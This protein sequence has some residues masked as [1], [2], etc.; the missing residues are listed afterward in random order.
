MK[1]LLSLLLAASFIL[2]AVVFPVSAESAEAFT[3][4][5]DTVNA[6]QA[7]SDIVVPVRLSG[8]PGISG[9]SFC[10]EYDTDNLVLVKSEITI[11][12]G[13]KVI[14]ETPG[15]GLNLAWTGTDTYTDNGTVA[16]LYFNI[17]PDATIGKADVRIKYR[18][19]YDS[20]YKTVDGEEQDIAVVS[21]NGG[22]NISN[23]EAVSG[24]KLNVGNASAALNETNIVIPISVENNTGISGFSFCVNYDTTRL[25]LENAD[26]A[27]SDGYKVTSKPDGYEVNIAWTS[28][29]GFAN[30]GII[31]NLHFSVKEN[32]VPGKGYINVLFRDSYDSFYKVVGGQETDV[33]CTVIN[34][35]I[36]VADHSYGDWIIVKEATCKETGLK[37]RICTDP[38]C[39]KTDEVIIPKAPHQYIG[40]VV[41]ATCEEQ[42]F[43]KHT[44]SV[45][46]DVFFDNYTDALPHSL[47]EWE[48]TVAPDCTNSGEEVQKCTVCQAVIN[49]R[50]I[51]ALGHSYGEWTVFKE[52]TFNE[53]G[54]SRKYCSKCDAYK[55]QR[56]PKLSETHTHDYSGTEEIITPA[57][58]TA[59]G[60]K[61]VYCSETECG[62]YIIE[63]IPKLAHEYG[64]WQITTEATFDTDGE[65]TRQ[66]KHCDAIETERIPKL[67]E[68]HIHD[69]TGREEIVKPATCTE[70]GEKKVYCLNA[71]CG[72]YSVVSIDIIDH[73]KGDWEITEQPT[74]NKTGIRVKKCTVCGKVLETESIAMTEHTLIDVVTP[75]TST[76]QG[77][78]THTCTECGYSY[79]DSYTD[80]VEPHVHDFSG[81][82]ELIEA[83]T[84]TKE[85][86]KK[87]YCTGDDCNEYTVVILPKIA[88]ITG[89]WEIIEPATCSKC[90]TKAKKCTACGKILETADVEMIPHS[91][92]DTVIP[93]TPTSQGYTIHRC[94]VCGYQY[95]DSYTDYV[96]ENPAKVV[97]ESKKARAGKT[98]LVNVSLQ[99][100]PGIWGMDLAVNYDKTKLTLIS[101]VNGSVFSDAEWTQG[102]LSGDKY[103]LSYEAGGFENITADGVIAILEFAVNNDAT[104]DEFYD[105]TVSYN[106][107]DI[108]DIDFNEINVAVVSGGVKI[109]EFIYGDLNGDGYINKKDSLLMKMYLADNSTAIDTDAADVFADGVINK[110]DS[111][112]LKQFLA[113]LDVELGA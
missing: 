35:Y 15:D 41:P 50:S 10:V 62:S 19:G 77:Y 36:D 103:I 43:T 90:G 63:T 111:L 4:S 8:N 2:S 31:A 48:Q 106:A 70:K 101:V 16:N 107:G 113:G 27:L 88:H 97:I 58:C 21:S 26:I 57:T 67:S 54:E 95:I 34:G 112:Y 14:R 40:T 20:F 39:G 86:S 109:I 13:Y 80:Y 85:G 60:S 12:S 7:Q 32:A 65:K 1:K 18:D 44:C 46:E 61:K 56:I 94:S 75:P 30:N 55:T 79:M 96:E 82:E 76:S 72:E 9:F 71:S 11:D 51:A 33:V 102:N 23:I 87:V 52:A 5:V 37:R 84:C 6:T 91:Y 105:I 64:E 28:E 108:I 104:V 59:E 49:R 45:C 98:V 100:N 42:G 38:D 110:K 47:G 53:D 69:F 99:N 78:T 83:A 3:V 73:V 89:E 22:V 74:C 92:I 25:S 66:C 68:G 24:L 17:V 29:S 93:P 81:S